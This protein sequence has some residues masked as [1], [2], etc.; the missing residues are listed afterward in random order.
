MQ[1]LPSK[2]KKFTPTIFDLDIVKA[3]IAM[4]KISSTSL[5][6]T[7]LYFDKSFDLWKKI[8]ED[9]KIFI[10]YCQTTERKGNFWNDV[11]KKTKLRSLKDNNKFEQNDFIIKLEEELKQSAIYNKVSLYHGD[12]IFNNIFY[13][14]Q[15]RLLKFIDPRGE[16][17][18]HWIYDI[19]KLYQCI[20]GKYDYIDSGLY[21]FYNNTEFYYDKGDREVQKAFE[22][23][24]LSEISKTNRSLIHSIATSL[25]LSMIP[26]HYENKRNQKILYKNYLIFKKKLVY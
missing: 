8:F 9:I 10:K 25:Y 3:K 1:N 7:F 5:R 19:A 15:K 17:F 11:I 16:F 4:E 13:D 14:Q 12:L 2:I 21:S 18:G 26:L 24:I 20:Y 23:T 22:E 6:D